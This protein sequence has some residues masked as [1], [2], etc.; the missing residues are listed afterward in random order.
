MDKKRQRIGI[1]RALYKKS[2]ILILDESTSALDKKTQKKILQNISNINDLTTI[3]IS[4][5]VSTLKYCNN[6][7]ELKPI[8]E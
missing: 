3:M 7:F 4:H 2:K 1:A 6:I 8:K 5:D